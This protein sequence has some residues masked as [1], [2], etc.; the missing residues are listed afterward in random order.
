MSDQRISNPNGVT[1]GELAAFLATQDPALP[2][3]ASCGCGGH[4]GWSTRAKAA[5]LSQ[6]T[7]TSNAPHLKIGW[8][9]D[10]D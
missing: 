4:G 7:A 8:S 10:D 3:A 2:V 6:G 9:G 5:Y 1:V